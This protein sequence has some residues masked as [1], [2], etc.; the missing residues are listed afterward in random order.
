[1]SNERAKEHLENIKFIVDTY[2]EFL[3]PELPDVTTTGAPDEDTHLKD[4]LARIQAIVDLQKAEEDLLTQEFAAHDERIKMRAAEAAAITKKIQAIRDALQAEAAA[5]DEFEVKWKAA[6][7]A[8]TA[9]AYKLRIEGN[10]MWE[11]FFY[12]AQ[13]AQEATR[14]WGEVMYDVG[15]QIDDVMSNMMINAIEDYI[16]KWKELKKEGNSTLK[17][18]GLAFQQYAIDVTKWL[19][20]IIAKELILMALRKMGGAG[21]GFFGMV[22]AGARQHGGPV[23]GGKPYLVGEKGPELFVPRGGGTIK[24]NAETAAIQP[25]VEVSIANLTDPA[26]IDAYMA[27]SRGQNAILNVIGQKS[28]QIRRMVR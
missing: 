22:A 27:S 7:A 12:G 24:S 20:K 15:T 17:I 6:M 3:A 10:N 9:E 18:L 5:E 13:T 14:E 4:A 28:G 16:G 21:G 11:N 19:A 25:T 26:V 23:A 2:K 8:V 1:M